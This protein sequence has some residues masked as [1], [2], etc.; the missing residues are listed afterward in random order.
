MSRCNSPRVRRRRLCYLWASRAVYV[1]QDFKS[2][3][4]RVCLTSKG[5]IDVDGTEYKPPAR[6]HRLATERVFNEMK[7]M[8]DL[9]PSIDR[10][11]TGLA[12]SP[13]S[14]VS[15]VG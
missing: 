3:R 9:C 8:A 4:S 2:R 15:T 1:S 6:S 10:N 5:I 12:G 7:W 13:V 14:C 11:Y